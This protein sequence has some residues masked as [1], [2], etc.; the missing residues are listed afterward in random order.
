MTFYIFI[1]DTYSF[2]SHYI[3]LFKFFL[4]QLI[5]YQKLERVIFFNKKGNIIL[6]KLH[7]VR[8]F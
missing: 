8:I 2:L 5:I 3:I 7:F 4:L 6:R 1:Y